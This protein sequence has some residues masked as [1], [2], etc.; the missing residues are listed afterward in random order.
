MKEY[1]DI[2]IFFKDGHIECYDDVTISGNN[3]LVE[4]TKDIPEIKY[5][6]NTSKKMVAGQ[7]TS[8][9]D[10]LILKQ[11]KLNEWK[12]VNKFTPTKIIKNDSIIRYTR[13]RKISAKSIQ[14]E[15]FLIKF[16]ILNPIGLEQNRFKFD[17][18]LKH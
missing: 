6:A 3:F 14:E 4:T 13:I 17:L 15:A 7:V 1:M 12:P 10:I 16:N 5:V 8:N 18:K 2:K 9:G 11:E